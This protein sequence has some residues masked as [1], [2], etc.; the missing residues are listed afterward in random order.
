M[1]KQR[2]H[3]AASLGRSAHDLELDYSFATTSG[4]EVTW[5]TTSSTDRAGIAPLYD[6]TSLISGTSR[7]KSRG[8]GER[9]A[10]WA[11]SGADSARMSRTSSR[12]CPPR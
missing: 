3:R 12:R 1:R 2:R 10:R 9:E 7:H 11:I 4:T 5:G 8:F 6:S